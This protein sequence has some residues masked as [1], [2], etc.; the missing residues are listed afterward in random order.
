MSAAA[1]G[2][3]RSRGS[4]S[5]RSLTRAVGP[6]LLRGVVAAAVLCLPVAVLALLVTRHF[7]PIVDLDERVV[8][9]A[10]DVTRAHP[11]FEDALIGWQSA[12]HPT[13]VYLYAI[14]VAVWTWLRGFRART[15]WGVVTMLVGWNLGL[16]VKLIVERAR[17]VIAD[18]VSH[19]PGYSF[20]SGH[21]FNVAMMVTTCLIM[22]WPLVRR[23]PPLIR[24]AAVTVGVLVVVLTML[25]RIFLGVHFQ[26][27]VTAGVL[28]AL[29][30]SAA[31]Y[32]G[33]SHRPK[34]HLKED[35]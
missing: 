18:P 13:M 25:D 17:P 19:A 28:L 20:P 8:V 12:F 15:I 23:W 29:G 14:P 7:A 24:A 26:S 31:S 6:R 2:G 11:G 33:F 35:S 16:Q 4:V 34:G 1:P 10:T 30:L 5:V 9:A 27:D 3:P 21:A 22:A 32:L